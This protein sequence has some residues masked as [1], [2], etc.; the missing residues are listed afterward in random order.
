MIDAAEENEILLRYM[1]LAENR[2]DSFWITIRG[3]RIGIGRDD[4]VQEGLIALDR[5]IFTYEED[6][7][8]GF[9]TYADRVIS[10]ALTDICRA[11]R[12][13]AESRLLDEFG[14]DG[15][16][17]DLDILEQEAESGGAGFEG[18]GACEENVIFCTSA[19]RSGPEPVCLKND[20]RRNLWN[21]YPRIP[22]R[23]GT[24]LWYRYGFTDDLFH[25]MQ[26][27][28]EHFNLRMK[29]A[30]EIEAKG[31]DLLRREMKVGKYEAPVQRTVRTGRERTT[32]SG[33]RFG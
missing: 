26:D 25:P 4:L 2:A 9:A 6:H 32:A 17:I 14:E 10:N 19:L 7:S 24:F 31:I 23:E 16:D 30:A 28:A 13:S 5:A 20:I 12:T 8:C 21:S 29:N 22:R 33:C 3:N 18:E 11:V 1:Y 15:A 27:T